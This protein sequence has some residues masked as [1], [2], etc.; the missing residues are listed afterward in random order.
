MANK[1]TILKLGGSVITKKSKPLTFNSDSVQ[2][3]S[4]VIK[5]FN[6]PLIIVH[7]AGSFGHYYAKRYRISD[8]PTKSTNH[9]VKIRDSMQ[10]LNQKLVKIFHKN[11]VNTFS[12]SPMY[13]YHNKKIINNWQSILKK[14][15]SLDL[16]PITF[17]D[18]LLAKNG[19]YIYSGDLIVYDLCKLLNPKRVIFASNIDGIY[20]NPDD[21]STLIPIIKNNMHNLKFSKLNYDVTGGIKTKITQSLK[22]AN[23]GID[24]QITNGLNSK[25]LIK[26]LMGEH[27]GTLFIGDKR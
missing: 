24:V 10:L 21:D 22:I 18:V 11:N 17:G 19:F 14:S 7:G 20:Q 23:L 6:E 4:K 9:V 8:K 3:I 16:I 26:A 13:M 1:L 12:F 2:K 5:K 27:V 15:I 25:T